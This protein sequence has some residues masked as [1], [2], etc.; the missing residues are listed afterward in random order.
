MSEKRKLAAIL[1]AD[2]VGYSR[3]ASEDEDRTLARLRALRSDLIDPTIAVHHGRM[4]K[5]TGDG[6]L[7]EFRSVVDAVR[8]AI[9][10]QNGM[11]ERNAGV[12]QDRRIEF[13]IGIHLG[14]VVEE[15]DG[16]LMGDG[17]NIASRLE[18]VAAPGA[19]CLSEDAYRQVRARLDLL[20]T[21]LGST[22]LK[23]IAE[24]IRVYSLR[25]GTAKSTT[26]ATSASATSRRTES[27]PPKLSIAV[28]PLVNMSGDAEQAFFTDGLTE[29]IITDLSNVPGFFVIARNSTFAYKG[30]S[31]DVRQIAHDLG[32]RYIL[33]GSARRSAERLRINVQLIDAAGG[34]NHVWAE[35]FDRDFA[36]IFVIQDEVTRRVVQAISGKIGMNKISTR[37]RPS[38]LEAYDLCVRSREKWAMSK[39]ENREALLALERAVALDPNYCEAHSNLAVSL[40]FGWINWG[41][42]RVSY[43][44]NALMHAQRA[45]EIDP[46]DSDA[47]SA[48]GYV[49]LYER[50]WDEAKS[51]LELAIRLNPNNANAGIWLAELYIYLGN[52]QDALTACAEALR[53]NPRPH[54]AYFWVLG[55]AQFAVGQ[56]DEA[57]ATLSRDETYGTGS[58]VNLIPALAFAG[59]VPDA[60]EEARLFLAGNPDWT[61]GE[62]AA[63]L[64]FRSMSAAQPFVDGWRMAG[65][66]D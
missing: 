27:T 47:C 41:E 35:R 43:Q 48:L 44:A 64:P 52:P 5:R 39:S 9:E 10:V 66:P 3:L 21:D 23:N 36:D 59:R 58:R 25:V 16:D 32:V 38:N 13:R 26:T 45:V 1:A 40:L 65:L 30:K 37:S 15:N 55:M 42:S 22:Q 29:D 50:N 60:R 2:V 28:L 18:G 11:I 34:G 33:E 19:I 54:H 24:P 31:I 51:L 8:C 12:P 57:M 49:Q 46:N 7:V 62:F 6:A 53:L 17:V 56:Y 61:I 14:D 20:V 63:N 4:V